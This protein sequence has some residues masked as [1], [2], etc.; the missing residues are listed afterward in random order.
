MEC[1]KEPSCARVCA[2]D[3]TYATAYSSFA[4]KTANLTVEVKYDCA[5]VWVNIH[6]AHFHIL[7]STRVLSGASRETEFRECAAH[8]LPPV[9]DAL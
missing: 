7:V 6:A 8:Y 1:D 3:G 5:H 9:S 2:N 4:R